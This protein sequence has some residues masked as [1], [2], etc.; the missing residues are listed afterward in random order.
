MN[1][2]WMSFSA[3]FSTAVGA[4][5]VMGTSPATS[6]PMMRSAPGIGTSSGS[7]PYFRKKPS[8][9]ATQSAARLAVTVFKPNRMD[10]G[11]GGGAAAELLGAGAPAAAGAPPAGAGA[12]ARPASLAAQPAV[13]ATRSAISSRRTVLPPRQ[14][15]EPRAPAGSVPRRSGPAPAASWAMPRRAGGAA[16]VRQQVDA[17]YTIRGDG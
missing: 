4:S 3:A 8:S 13:Y 15:V 16:P 11:A 14:V 2:M 6:A 1:W 5:V 12:G 9:F 10:T 17:G 7:R